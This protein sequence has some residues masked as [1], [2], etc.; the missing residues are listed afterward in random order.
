MF[1]INFFKNVAKTKKEIV[2]GNKKCSDADAIINEF[3]GLRNEKPYVFN[4]ETTNYCNMTCVM[5]PRTDLMTRKNMWIDDDAFEAVISQVPKHTPQDVESFRQFVE[6]D[7]CITPETRS[8]NAFYFQVSANH[9]TL[10]GYGEPLLDKYIVKRLETC[11]KYN[12]PTYFS[13]VPA[14]IDVKK[15]AS[16]MELGLGVIKFSIDALDDENQKR[17]R[18]KRNDF[19][20]SYQKIQQLLEIKK[21]KGFDTTIVATMIAMEDTMESRELQVQ[22]LDLWKDKDI[23]AYVKS[24]DNR[25]LY[26]EDEKL[27]SK[28][29]YADQYC[30]FPWLSLTVMANGKVVPCTQDY[31]AEMVM[32]DVTESSLEEIW[33]GPKYKEFR[34]WHVTGEFP[35]G[36]KCS[37]RCDLR[38]LHSCL[39]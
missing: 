14:N 16:L 7:Y 4:V 1:D 27:Q 29:H 13:C 23:F 32:G 11:K 19:S 37:S 38:K 31:D 20:S 26:D 39:K 8:E 36:F 24:Q 12:V 18:G 2:S 30:E 15:I 34:R 21:E 10:H 25:W 35:E 9:V 5:C 28:S 3:E 6:E 22:F 33:N 17:I